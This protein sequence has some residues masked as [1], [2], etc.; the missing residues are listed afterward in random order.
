MSAKGVFSADGST[1]VEK[2]AKLL[3]NGCPRSDRNRA[4]LNGVYSN[5]RSE[6]LQVLLR[7]PLRQDSP[8]FH[9][10]MPTRAGQCALHPSSQC[11]FHRYGHAGNQSQGARTSKSSLQR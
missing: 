2:A 10:T 5:S 1:I 8:C 11:E 6:N 9:G 3:S 7:N 4:D